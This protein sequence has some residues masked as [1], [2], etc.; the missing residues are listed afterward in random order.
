MT[1]ADQSEE[2][3]ALLRRITGEIWTG[4]RLEFIGE[5]VSEGF[6]DHGEMRDSRARD[7]SATGHRSNWSEGPFRITGTT[8]FAC[9]R[10][11]TSS[12]R[13]PA[14]VNR[15]QC[16]LR[17]YCRYILAKWMPLIA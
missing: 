13:S 8:S 15:V 7:A 17:D 2:S 10:V 14:R 16:D 3:K 12:R 9:H 5:L 11:A 6:V 4:W 1:M